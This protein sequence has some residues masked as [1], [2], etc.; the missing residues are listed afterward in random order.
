MRFILKNGRFSVDFV[1]ENGR[2]LKWV[3]TMMV[4]LRLHRNRQ[5][6]RV[7]CEKR[8][9]GFEVWGPREPRRSLP[10]RRRSSIVPHCFGLTVAHI[11]GHF[12]HGD[13]YGEMG[14]LSTKSKRPKPTSLQSSWM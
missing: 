12:C 14:Y 9:V 3:F 10:R 5:L 13:R 11:T 4:P 1:P 8:T 6:Q 2:G 7:K